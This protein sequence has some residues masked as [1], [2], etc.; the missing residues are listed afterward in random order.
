MSDEKIHVT[1]LGREE[2]WDW[3]EIKVVL[4]KLSSFEGNLLESKFDLSSVARAV[5]IWTMQLFLF[6]SRGDKS[7]A[8]L[9]ITDFMQ[10]GWDVVCKNVFRSVSDAIKEK[11]VH[12]DAL[13]DDDISGLKKLVVNLEMMQS[14]EH[15]IC[16]EDIAKVMLA[17]RSLASSVDELSRVIDPLSVARALITMAQQFMLFD[18]GGDILSAKTAFTDQQYLL[19]GLAVLNVRNMVE[20]AEKRTEAGPPEEKPN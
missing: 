14:A 4:S 16:A 18:M 7:K 12:G 9:L 17:Q 15:A 10:E 20:E 13:S 3:E 19:W 11:E 8:T 5:L 2:E 6:G 1:D